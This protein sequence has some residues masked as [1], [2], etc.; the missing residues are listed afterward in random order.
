MT[1]EE[2]CERVESVRRFYA[3]KAAYAP[4]AEALRVVLEAARANPTAQLVAETH[5]TVT[6]VFRET[7]HDFSQVSAGSALC[8]RC[9]SAES[10]PIHQ[11]SKETP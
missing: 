8:R 5:A 2:A 4:T 11:Q 7:P 3:D 9:L 6:A 1:L 10:D